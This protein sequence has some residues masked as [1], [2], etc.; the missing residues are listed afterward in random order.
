[1]KL[2]S[3][4]EC[5]GCLACINSC[6]KNALEVSKDEEGF[7]IPF[8]IKERCIDCGICEK[9]CPVLNN[10]DKTEFCQRGYAV[11]TRDKT[12]R[13]RSSSGGIFSELALDILKKGG[14][15]F[16]AAFDI[17]FR[18]SH[19]LVDKEE[20][21]NKLRGSKYLQSD[22]KDSFKRAKSILKDGRSVLFSGTPCQIAGLYGYLNRDYE[23]LVT[24]DFI[25]HGVPSPTVF[26]KYK[27]WLEKKYNSQLINYTFRD[28]R[29]SWCWFNTKADFKSGD[30]YIGTWFKDPFMRLFLR[31]NILRK[32]CYQC[33]FTNMDRIGDVTI[34][35]F[36]GYKATCR[37]DRDSDKGIS[38]LLINSSKGEEMF[39]ELKENIV[40]FERSL[41]SISVSQKSL[42]SAW[43]RPRTREEFWSDFMKMEFNEIINKWGYP[44]KRN[45]GQFLI[46]E[47]G[48]NMFTT[49][50]V[51]VYNRLFHH[52]F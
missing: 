49:F 13:R 35:D 34:A 25:C 27:K 23:N 28:K 30:I 43:E 47:Y 6:P 48:K 17:D 31:D 24:C 33:C 40:Y 39:E 12:I 15:V 22:I 11:W 21:L 1:M 2:C 16:G 19:I 32:S 36:W 44:E 46:S 38:L 50:I 20:D 4:S 9:S 7:N 41:D 5:T 52:F 42:S 10:I 37:K 18:V 29:K 3:P 45:F 14:V 26:L 51:R 8:F